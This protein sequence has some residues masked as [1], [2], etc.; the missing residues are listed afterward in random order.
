MSRQHS[1]AGGFTLVE[2]VVAIVLAAIVASF[3]VL[4]LDAPVQAYFA[5]TRRA[6]LEDSA[7]RIATA[8]SGDVRTALPNSVR[9][10]SAGATQA[11]ELLATTGVARYYAT[12]DN[13]PGGT[14]KELAAGSPVQAFATLDSFDTQALPYRVPYVAVGNLGAPSAYDA[15][16]S[17]SGVMTPVTDTITVT[18]NPATPP[19]LDE[20][21]VSLTPAMTFQNVVAPHNAYLVSGPV[22]YVCDPVAGT[23]RRY[24]G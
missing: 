19:A 12:G 11:L 6:D 7:N 3:I 14:E 23:L 24:S 9:A 5:Q 20:N 22:S 1:K 2:L 8:V 4:F 15:Y 18:A 16:N 17:T 13:P 21:Q 10:A